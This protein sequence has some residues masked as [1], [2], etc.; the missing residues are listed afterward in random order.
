[1]SRRSLVIVV[2][3]SL[4]LNLFLIGGLVGGLVV[5]ERL[6][7]QTP[8]PGARGGPALWAAANSLPPEQR[9]AYRRML[10]GEGGEVRTHLR[11]A[12]LARAEVW[13]MLADERL[14]VDLAKQR[15]AAA[16]AMEMQARGE[17]ENRIVDFTAGLPAPERAQLAT[18]LAEPKRGPAR[19]RRGPADAP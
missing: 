7:T 6:R 16:R 2:F 10:R 8:T 15:L 19:Q 13:R 3:V 17:V 4:A 18:A 5:G 1:M 9:R 11:E 14:D 12:R